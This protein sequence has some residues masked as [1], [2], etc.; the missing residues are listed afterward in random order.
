[1]S[2][3][4]V[5]GIINRVREADR[6]S[7]Q[8]MAWIQG[9]LDSLHDSL[10]I[11]GSSPEEALMGFVQDYLV[12]APD[13]LSWIRTCV[14]ACPH[15]EVESSDPLQ[16]VNLG[17]TLLQI[18]T[19]YYLAPA[20]PLLQNTGLPGVFLR[21]YQSLRLL[22]ECHDNNHQLLTGPAAEL[23]LMAPNLLAHL[24]IGEPFANEL[25]EALLYDYQKVVPRDGYYR[26]HVLPDDVSAMEIKALGQRCQDVL[27]HNGLRF[28]FL[29][30]HGHRES[31]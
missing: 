21:S 6:R 4:A 12:L 2:L 19:D 23:S 17:R 29:D 10:E 31:G 13:I 30:D 11:L 8:G 18:T 28:R 22:E 16:P 27:S 5:Y 15:S 25:D 7:Q 24:L 3:E 1:M 26:L 20:T 9:R 14:E